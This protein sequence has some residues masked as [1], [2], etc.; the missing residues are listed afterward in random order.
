MDCKICEWRKNKRDSSDSFETADSLAGVLPITP[1]AG[2]SPLPI[3]HYRNCKICEK[4]ES[5]C[6]AYFLLFLFT[7][8]LRIKYNNIAHTI[9]SPNSIINTTPPAP[10]ARMISTANAIS[11]AN[12]IVNNIIL[13]SSFHYRNCK[14]CE[15]DET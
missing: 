6:R 3:S 5:P 8:F 12:S 14:I 4:K 13:I 7:I 11:T 1:L 15:I 2:Y 10:T 9:T